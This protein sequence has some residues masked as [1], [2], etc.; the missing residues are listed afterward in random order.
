MKTWNTIVENLK[1]GGCEHTVHS[2][3]SKME[4]VDSVLADAETGAITV[5]YSGAYFDEEKAIKILSN[6]GY[7]PEGTSTMTDKVKSYVSCAV[8]KLTKDN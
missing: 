6:A 7:T 4:G 3:L 1:C 2:L 5:H 8:G